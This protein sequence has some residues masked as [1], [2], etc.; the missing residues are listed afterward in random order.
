MRRPSFEVSSARAEVLA[1]ITEITAGLPPT[2]TCPVMPSSRLRHQCRLL[3][4][5]EPDAGEAERGDRGWSA[6]SGLN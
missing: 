1:R 4:Q 2:V 5:F 3:R 6:R